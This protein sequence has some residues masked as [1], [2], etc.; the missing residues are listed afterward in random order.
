MNDRSQKRAFL[1]SVTLF[2]L[3]AAHGCSSEPQQPRLYGAWKMYLSDSSNTGFQRHGPV[4]ISRLCWERT[5]KSSSGPDLSNVVVSGSEVYTVAADGFLRALDPRSGR[6]VWRLQIQEQ[7][8]FD[9]LCSNGKSVFYRFSGVTAAIDTESRRIVWVKGTRGGSWSSPPIEQDGMLFFGANNKRLY[10]VDQK[11]GV[12]RWQAELAGSVQEQKPP[13]CSEGNVYVLV[14]GM[15]GVLHLYSHDTSDGRLNWEKR[16]ERAGVETAIASHNGRLF[17][18]IGDTFYSFDAISGEPMWSARTFPDI[19]SFFLNDT[20]IVLVLSD[21]DGNWKV[22]SLSLE[23][24]ELGRVYAGGGGGVATPIIG[25]SELG[26]IGLGSK[27]IVVLDLNDASK[28]KEFDTGKG[29]PVNLALDD[30]GLYV[31]TSEGQIMCI[32]P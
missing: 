24:G 16:L 26:V 29:R 30:R 23:T 19:R 31:T 8:T 21:L 13:C 15:D 27:K 25:T 4:S 20:Q 5:F 2:L 1:A 18:G 10:A 3:I 22:Q 32:V 9:G 12:I 11:T 7:S 17:F 28:I 6:E 14:S